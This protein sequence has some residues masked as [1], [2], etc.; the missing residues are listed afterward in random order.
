MAQGGEGSEYYSYWERT[1]GPDGGAHPEG[2]VEI[3]NEYYVDHG[4]GPVQIT[5]HEVYDAEGNLIEST[6][7][8]SEC[9]CPHDPLT[10]IP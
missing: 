3:Y 1:Y 5:I 7:N 4:D 9:V 6:Y 2:Y 8:N 10:P